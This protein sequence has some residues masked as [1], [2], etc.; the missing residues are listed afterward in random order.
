[1]NLR[2]RT[3]E[4]RRTV[5]VKIL[6]KGVLP[7]LDDIDAGRFFSVTTDSLTRTTLVT[8]SSRCLLLECVR[9]YRLFDTD[10]RNEKAVDVF[11]TTDPFDTP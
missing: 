1:M 3:F 11:V 7:F 10:N 2:H 4:K 5:P 9:H 8:N 6:R